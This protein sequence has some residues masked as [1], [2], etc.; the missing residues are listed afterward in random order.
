MEKRKENRTTFLKSVDCENRSWY[1]FD[2]SG[3]TLGRLSSEIAK[4]LRGKHKVT[5][6]PYMPS[7]DGVIVI[8]AEKVRLTGAKKA[9]KI[10]RYYTGHIGGMREIPFENMLARKPD[11]VI[12]HAVKGMMPK[13][14]LGR[15]QLKSL[16][17]VKGASFERYVAQ[18]P[19]V[20]NI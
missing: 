4:V 19:I 6:T 8:N 12:E 20:V 13:T 14:K 16:R 15:K 17:V 3:K 9:Q 5:F 10:Y 1:L 2:A 7:G 11:Y 18:K